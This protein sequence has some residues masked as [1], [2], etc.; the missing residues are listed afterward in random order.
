MKKYFLTITLVLLTFVCCRGDEE[1][2]QTI[3]QVLNLYIHNSAGQDMLN[4]KIDGSYTSINLVDLL[5][6]TA[7]KPI[8]GYSLIKDADTVT[9]LDYPAG[10]VRLLQ[11]SISP[12]EKI[13]YSNFIIQLVTTKNSVTT[14]DPDTIRIEYKW[15]PSLFQLSKLWYND[16]LK[17]TKVQGQRNVVKIVK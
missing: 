1:D 8:T 3:D 16:E 17:F 13:Y 4:S 7:L 5:D 15:T 11:D 12:E 2:I 6:E 14:T 9:Y 10:A